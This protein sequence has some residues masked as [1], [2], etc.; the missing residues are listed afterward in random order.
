MS[1]NIIIY[2]NAIFTGL[3]EE[4]EELALAI[5]NNK[6]VSIGA[7]DDIMSLKKEGTKE[8]DAG[9]RLVMAGFHDSHLH[10]MAGILFT[11]YSCQL[12]TSETLQDA[13]T[14]LKDYADEQADDEWVIGTGWS[15]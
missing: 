6:I 9:D 11:E 2:G 10:L 13:L 1:T 14:N 15:H 7:Y 3:K 5:E 12:S 8:I 4:P